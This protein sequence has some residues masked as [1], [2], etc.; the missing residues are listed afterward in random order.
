MM[1]I[2]STEAVVSGAV[3]LII[4]PVAFLLWAW[5]FLLFHVLSR[6]RFRAKFVAQVSGV[7]SRR[8]TQS[9]GVSVRESDTKGIRST[10]SARYSGVDGLP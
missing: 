4:F 10:P 8:L 3:L 2:G 9:Q 1:S 7:G 6:H 5:N